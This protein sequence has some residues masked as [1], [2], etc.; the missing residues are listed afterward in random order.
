MR[1]F[2][3]VW[4]GQAVS[5]LGTGM[6]N[7]AL[8]IWAYQATGKATALALVSFSYVTPML[9]VSPLA[10]A[11]VDRSNRKLMMM[12]SDLGAGLATVVIFLLHAAGVLEVWHLYLAALIAGTTQT[13]QWPAYSAAITV[14]IPKEHYGRASGLNQLA[15]S[16][17]GI[18]APLLAG[19][20]IGLVGLRGI[21]LIDI[22]TFVFAVSALLLVHIPQPKRTEEG[23]AGAGSLWQEAFFGFRY[24][25]ERSS[26]LGLQLVFLFGN[27][28]GEIGFVVI[29]PMIL[30]HTGNSEIS[31]GTVQSAGAVGGVAG[32][33]LMSLWG[34]PRKRVNGVLGGWAVYGVAGMMLLGLGR[35]V[36]WWAAASFLGAL[37]VPV[38]N[39]S[40]QAIWQAK[41]A[42]D[43]QGRVFSSRR[44]I[45]WLVNPL[46]MLLAGPLA[47]V[48][49]EPSMRAGGWVYT[50]FHPLVGS[51]PGAG[52]AGIVLVTGLLVTCVGLGGYAFRS[53]REAE[54]LLPDHVPVAAEEGE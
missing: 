3:M 28:F 52:M 11:L 42:P 30:A 39:G 37:V 41:V 29:T 31:L 20:L 8:T 16:A 25:F 33:L 13:F 19:A 44:V 18:F 5:L 46:S 6:S 45:A 40:N 34:G 38:V 12:V 9:L 17:S 47:D 51:G 49:M 10:G 35:T 50:L 48:V 32:A 21:L 22:V 2:L 26:L 24:I 43:V 54:T 15:D 1:A 23:R 36:P 53:V 7:F 4:V 14:M 27:F